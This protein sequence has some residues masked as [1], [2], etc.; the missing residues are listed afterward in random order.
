M[1]DERQLFPYSATDLRGARVL[2]LAP[3]PDDETIACG[4]SLT[5]HRHAGDPVRVIFVTS[6]PQREAE[7]APALGAL[8]VEHWTFW[9]HVDREVVA[10]RLVRRLGQEFDTY[11]PTL[12]YAPSPLDLHPDH[13]AV[14]AAVRTALRRR[15]DG[16]RVAFFETSFA[17]PVNT[18]VDVSTVWPAKERAL[19]AYASQREVRHDYLAA[20]TGLGRFRA[21]TL[22]RP[23][24]EAEGYHVV[25]A[26]DVSGSRIWRWQA[27]QEPRP[28]LRERLASVARSARQ[29]AS[30]Q[31]RCIPRT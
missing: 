20:M 14:A 1:V 7:V 25:E 31:A 3:H 26:G 30:A 17:G 18:L 19:A 22:G 6:T 5:L 8:G 16:P 2:V 9:R 15:V 23:S 10:G 12:L 13:R 11:R 24:T 29:R 21:L 28:L 27:L 4:G